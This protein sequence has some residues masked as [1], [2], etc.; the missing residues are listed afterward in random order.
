MQ[1]VILA[2]GKGAR[3]RPYTAV[4]PKPLMPIGD[5]PVL[6]IVVRQLK[7][8]GF[9]EI[10]MAVGHLAALIETYF[11]DGSQWG[12]PIRY[13]RE[14][15]PLG[16]A[17]PIALIEGL[18]P[19]FMVMNGDVLTSL[20]YR[21]FMAWHAASG[22][23]ASVAMCRKAVE[24]TLGVLELGEGSEIRQYVEKPTLQYMASMGVYAF[25][26][27]VCAY[28]R[29]GQYL[30]FPDLI[31]A[32]LA[33]GRSVKGYDFSGVWLDIGRRE[34]YEQAIEVFEGHRHEILP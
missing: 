14:A 9:G 22:A 19:P 32:L 25:S 21:E 17:G 34:D 18:E 29:R 13:S 10:I 28:L 6:E 24:V 27:A 7:R 26:G 4:L 12:L 2:G 20:D 5:I 16:T 23:A 3:L 1:A 33:D 8:A 30:D 11:G 31:K 15:E